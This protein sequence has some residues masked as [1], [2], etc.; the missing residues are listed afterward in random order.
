MKAPNFIRKFLYDL[1][2]VYLVL[3]FI[4]KQIKDQKHKDQYLKEMKYVFDF[5]G[6]TWVDESPLELKRTILMIMK[7]KPPIVVNFLRRWK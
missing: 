4:Y 3:A 1:C 6:L 2:T 5:I 7:P